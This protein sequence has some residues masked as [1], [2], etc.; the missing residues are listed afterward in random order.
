MQPP[1]FRYTAWPQASK[2][3]RCPCQVSALSHSLPA[4]GRTASSSL[5]SLAILSQGPSIGTRYMVSKDGYAQAMVAGTVLSI[6]TISLSPFTPLLQQVSW[7]IFTTHT[8]GLCTSRKAACCHHHCCMWHSSCVHVTFTV[9]LSNCVMML[10]D[11]NTAQL[12]HQVRPSQLQ[13]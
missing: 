4:E 3:S 8:P 7:V 11:V 10:M 12:Q 9:T 6:K 2:S 5:P 1:G 13:C